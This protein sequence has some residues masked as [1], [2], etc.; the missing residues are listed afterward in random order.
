VIVFGI[1]SHHSHELGPGPRRS[2]QESLPASG[3]S[4][5]GFLLYDHKLG[6]EQS[7]SVIVRRIFQR[8]RDLVNALVGIDNGELVGN[9]GRPRSRTRTTDLH[10]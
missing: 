5:C 6:S 10:P 2:W 8:G 4:R 1:D 9:I 3:V 7:W